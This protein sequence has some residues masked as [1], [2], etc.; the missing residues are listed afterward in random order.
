MSQPPLFILQN[1]ASGKH[2]VSDLHAALER[3]LGAAKREYQ[4]T[5]VSQRQRLKQSIHDV[6]ERAKRHGGAVIVAGGDGTINTVA[7]A[8]LPTGCAFGVLPQGT[9][10]Y[11][12]RTHGIPE[13]AEAAVRL[14]LHAQPQP[15]Q[16]GLVNGRVI[17]V[18]ASLGLY[19]KLLED[20]ESSKRR[21]GRS[22]VVAYLAGLLS[23]LRE[24]HPLQLRMETRGRIIDIQTPTLFIGN[25]RLQMESVGMREAGKIE[26]GRMVAIALRPAGNMTLL[27]LALRGALGKLGEAREVLSFGV[28][29]LTVTHA[30]RES[31]L[32][33]VAVDG[34]ILH[35]QE[36]LRF[37]VS[38]QPLRLLKAAPARDAQR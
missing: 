30:Q 38:P 26:A 18:N 11:F 4:Y 32:V 14:L 34:E 19:P 8:V 12:S 3:V 2:R 22:R 6:V 9:F 16:V 20:R 35:L 31:R 10:N 29:E 5:L 13:D 37:A 21:F 28:D 24:R 15:V 25:N 17:L 1:A 7:N 27:K 36:P 23:L 33:R